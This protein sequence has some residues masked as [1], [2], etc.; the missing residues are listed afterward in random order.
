MRIKYL[1]VDTDRLIDSCRQG[2]RK[3][4]RLLYEKYASSMLGICRRYLPRIDEAEDALMQGFTKVF[5]QLDKLEDSSKFDFWIRRI[6]AN[7]CLMILRKKKK[8]QFAEINEWDVPALNPKALDNLSTDDILDLVNALPDGY[9]T[10]FNLY[11]I[12]GYKHKEIAE[13]LNISI[14]TSKS[15]LIMA[16]R[17]LQEQLQRLEQ[18]SF[19]QKRANK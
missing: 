3:A 6:M 13:M 4:Q 16:R 5:R 7:E 14:N 15:Q 1:N 9:R 2:D 17:K 12:E 8:M 18:T 11:V 19:N 10:I